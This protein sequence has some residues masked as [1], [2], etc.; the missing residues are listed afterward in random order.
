MKKAI[1]YI[2][3]ALFFS[4]ILASFGC[5]EDYYDDGGILDDS[6]GVLDMTTMQYLEKHTESFDTLVSLIKLCGLEDSVDA[7][8][9]TFF[10]PQDYSIH[11]YFKL[12]FSDL[13]E[14]PSLSEFTDDEISGI[15]DILKE[16]IVPGKKIIRD[17]LSTSYSYA[18]TLGG[19][20]ARLNLTQEDYLGNVDMGATYIVYSFNVGTTD[21]ANY[22]SVD[23]VTS[24]L[25]STTGI[26][27]VL[28]STSH[29]FG[30][31]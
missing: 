26:V 6:V 24:D 8:G 29:I 12:I 10:A 30:F 17:S 31:N 2:T 15:S 25:Q 7:K 18:T 13:D 14:W 9:S 23:V 27:H 3:A 1:R 20:S 21:A 19:G 16:Y 5:K 11:N 22:Q 28:S 4:I